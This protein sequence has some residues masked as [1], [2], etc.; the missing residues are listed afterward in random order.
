MRLITL[1]CKEV[2]LVFCIGKTVGS[3]ARC[4][5]SMDSVYDCVF[6]MRS[7]C[8][9]SDSL[10]ACIMIFDLSSCRWHLKSISANPFVN[11]TF[12][13]P[14]PR[15]LWLSLLA[16]V[17]VVCIILIWRNLFECLLRTWIEK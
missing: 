5:L 3:E 7:T 2:T 10:A 15:H 4:G 12:G 8:F 1:I 16:L 11:S 13:R 6:C 9:Y 17:Y 14:T